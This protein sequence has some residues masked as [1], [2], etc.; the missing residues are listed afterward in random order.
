MFLVDNS[1][2]ISFASCIIRRCM[3]NY[4][5]F[6]VLASK[7]PTQLF[8]NYSKKILSISCSTALTETDYMQCYSEL[9]WLSL[10]AKISQFAAKINLQDYKL[11]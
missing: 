6:N 1:L 11:P 2:P 3:S 7:K 9:M 5:K 10:S 8:Q 4:P